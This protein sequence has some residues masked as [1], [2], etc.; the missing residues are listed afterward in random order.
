M[1]CPPYIVSLC[2][3]AARPWQA[4][5]YNDNG[6][7][8]VEIISPGADSQ[9]GIISLL[10]DPASFNKQQSLAFYREKLPKPSGQ[11]SFH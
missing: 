7:V 11:T 10:C 2:A 4:W 9:P 6:H 8:P 1:E 5:S 3:H